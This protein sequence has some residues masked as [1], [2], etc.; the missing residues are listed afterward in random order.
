[1]RPGGAETA[2]DA[3]YSELGEGMAAP[4]WSPAPRRGRKRGAPRGGGKKQSLDRAADGVRGRR[5][6]CA[7]M[8]VLRA[9]VRACVRIYTYT[10][11]RV[12]EE[13]AVEEQRE[14]MREASERMK[15]REKEE[16][17]SDGKR[18]KHART[19]ERAG[20]LS[21]NERTSESKCVG[22]TNEGRGRNRTT[23]REAYLR[24]VNRSRG[25]PS[26]SVRYA[27]R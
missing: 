22:G 12:C 8:R 13:E 27:S 10:F 2:C 14:T 6:R 4:R 17:G 18:V 26:F 25:C 20:I 9:C 19:R 5:L 11:A 24:T 15:K 16:T 7:C 23:K 3:R 21:E 1:M